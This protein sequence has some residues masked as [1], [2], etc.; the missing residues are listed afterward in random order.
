MTATQRRAHIAAHFEDAPAETP[1]P[2]E[3]PRS[4]RERGRI[5]SDVVFEAVL[6]LKGQLK[7]RDV[8]IVMAAAESILNLEQTRMRHSAQLAG[9]ELVSEAQE[10]FETETREES[11]RTAAGPVVKKESATPAPAEGNRTD[12]QALV[13]HAQEITAAFDGED[14]PMPIGRARGFVRA[15]LKIW[16]I[17]ATAIPRGGFRTALLERGRGP[18]PA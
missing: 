16:A 7:N 1:E 3:I 12:A 14:E 5:W 4:V 6:A 8:A 15:Q 17:E 13:E 10:K 9:S 11:E 18:V 2:P